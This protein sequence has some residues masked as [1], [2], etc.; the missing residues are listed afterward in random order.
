[1]KTFQIFLASLVILKTI[2]SSPPP[3]GDVEDEEFFTGFIHPDILDRRTDPDTLRLLDQIRSFSVP[4]QFDARE[5]GWI[6]EP[7]HQKSCGSCVVFTNVALIET[8]IARVNCIFD[9][10]Q[11][12]EVKGNIFY[13]QTIA[14]IFSL[15]S[16]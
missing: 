8:C 16:E 9:Q 5:E 2:H 3:A 11:C 15:R 7:K 14:K 12:G 1:M 6:G 4:D 10:D 13:K